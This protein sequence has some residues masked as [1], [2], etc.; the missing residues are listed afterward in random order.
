[1]TIC[2]DCRGPIGEDH[3]PPDGWQLEDGRTV[4]HACSV[5]DLK[6][7]AADLKRRVAI[8]E[9]LLQIC[10]AL[11]IDKICAWLNRKLTQK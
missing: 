9:L 5:R 11:K 2:A 1:M 7:Y 4:C 10:Y 8:R 3:G 6:S